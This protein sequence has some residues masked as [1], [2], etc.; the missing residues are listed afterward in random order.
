MD[1]V[2]HD[3]KKEEWDQIASNYPE[4]RVIGDHGTIKKCTGC[5]GCW[6]KTPGQCVIAD[7]Y[8]KMGEWLAEADKVMIISKCCFG[9]YSP[10][11]KNVLDRSISYLL[12]YF[13]IRNGE[14]HHKARYQKQLSMSVIFY[15]EKI[16]EEERD[17]AKKL[18]E[19]NAMNFQARADKV[20]FTGKEEVCQKE[21]RCH[22]IW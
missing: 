11:V 4:T 2:I 21:G 5:F 3:L 15:G 1:L 17:T 7:D 8:Q 14:M 13:E 10:F 19:A 9:C 6:V 20:L 22:E 16:T 12:P 18:V